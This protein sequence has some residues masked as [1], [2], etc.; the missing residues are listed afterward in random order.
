MALRCLI[1]RSEPIVSRASNLA[2]FS[3]AGVGAV[4]TTNLTSNFSSSAAPKPHYSFETALRSAGLKPQPNPHGYDLKRGYATATDSSSQEKPS[5]QGGS[6]EKDPWETYDSYMLHHPE[7][8]IDNRKN[9]SPKHREPRDLV[10]KV[11]F[12]ACTA[13]R[14]VFDYVTG[15]GPN[16][17]ERK[18]LRRFI[19]LETIAGVPGMVAGMLRHMKS[20]RSLQ[21]DNGWIHT[22][23]EEAENERMHLLT[24][25]ELR[26][27]GIL[28]RMAVLGAQGVFFNLFFLSYVISPRLSHRFVSYLEE[29]AVCTY[30]HAISDLD[31]G[32]LPEWTNKPAPEIAI[33]YWRLNQDATL[34]D[35]LEVIRADEATHSHVNHTFA[36]MDTYQK[37]PFA[38][39]A[40]TLPENFVDPP[41]GF[42][43]ANEIKA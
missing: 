4:W 37:N 6:R 26:Q 14:T 13:M 25:L 42:K 27:P 29:E 17:N 9:I 11:A 35:V 30:T 21:R 5:S 16:M 20:L 43:P 33:G 22:L 24:F 34:K 39:G 23:L 1:A 19:F 10:D 28:F 18:W 3:Q 31:S 36:S 8:C 7:H 12:G 32:K 15:Y 2:N 38:K 40:T 41:P